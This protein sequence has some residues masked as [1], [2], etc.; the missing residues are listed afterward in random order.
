[1]N[2]V[3]KKKKKNFPPV[4]TPFL[5]LWPT[6]EPIVLLSGQRRM[7]LRLRGG[8]LRHSLKTDDQN[9]FLNIVAAHNE[10]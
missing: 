1:M 4:R 3:L 2:K 8:L 5:S 6:A 10:K 9:F 7:L